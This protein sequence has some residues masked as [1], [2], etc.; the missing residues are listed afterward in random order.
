M[1]RLTHLLLSTCAEAEREINPCPPRNARML[2][3]VHGGGLLRCDRSHQRR[4]FLSMRRDLHP[5]DEGPRK[6]S[7]SRLRRAPTEPPYYRYRP[8]LHDRVATQQATPMQTRA[9]IY[10]SSAAGGVVEFSLSRPKG[11][12]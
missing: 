2:A 1:T 6:A 8:G 7:C 12:R 11:G 5:K 10:F 3:G 9:P 4:C